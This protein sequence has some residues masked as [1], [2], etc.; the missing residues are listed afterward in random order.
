MDVLS[1]QLMWIGTRC[2]RVNQCKSTEDS[3][4]PD[5]EGYV[6]E[7]LYGDD[8]R[9]DEYEIEVNEAGKYQTAFHVPA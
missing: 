8:D 1:P 6:E 2:Y 7:D 9:E 4:Q 5:G 3:E